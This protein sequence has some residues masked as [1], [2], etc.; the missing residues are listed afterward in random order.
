LKAACKGW[1]EAI[2]AYRFFNNEKVTEEAVLAP[3]AYSDD[4]ER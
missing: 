4:R 3:H 2:A 1:S